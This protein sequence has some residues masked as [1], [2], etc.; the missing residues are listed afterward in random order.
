MSTPAPHQGRS[1]PPPRVIDG[2]G[3]AVCA[4]ILGLAYLTGLAPRLRERAAADEHRAQ[5]DTVRQDLARL[6]GERRERSARADE[7]DDRLASGVVRLR[8]VREVNRREDEIVKL[9]EECGLR[10]A[11]VAPGV[12]VVREKFTVVPIRVRGTGGYAEVTALAARAHE[13]FPDTAASAL[14]IN[15]P[16]GPGGESEFSVE[17]A[18][19]AAPDGAARAP[20]PNQQK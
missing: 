14:T 19:H 1:V 13:R 6:T 10:V 5:L 16:A 11:E 4:I 20:A 18:W 17:F 12:P 3:V 15:G 9:A 7:L 2:A 8:P